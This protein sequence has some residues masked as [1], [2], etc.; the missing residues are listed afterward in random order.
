MKIRML[1]A[2]LALF[3]FTTFASTG[4]T[5]CQESTRVDT[6]DDTVGPEDSG[7]YARDLNEVTGVMID[8]LK[9]QK[10]SEN[11]KS[12]YKEPPIIAVIRAQN[13]TRFPEVTQVFQEDLVT[14]MMEKFTREE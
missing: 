10:I 11:F 9:K 3:G 5:G 12:K 4:A 13:D 14:A 2:M 6:N 7:P 8:K 1:M